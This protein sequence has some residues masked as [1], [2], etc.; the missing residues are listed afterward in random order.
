MTEKVTR[1]LFLAIKPDAVT[2]AAIH[3]LAQRLQKAARFTPADPKWVPLEN[4]HLTLQFLGEVDGPKADR[5]VESF[6]NAFTD[7]EEFRLDFRRI[8]FFPA[9]SN[10]P[11]RVIWIGVHNA[12]KALQTVRERAAAL[13]RSL[14][15]SLTEQ[16]FTPHL[17][18]ARLKSTKGLGPLRSILDP[19]R[20]W[21]CG[22]SA[23]REIHL[24]ES[25]T[26]GGVARYESLCTATLQN[27]TR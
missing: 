4:I 1:R 21:K 17:T 19:Y 13:I 16:A 25:H 7:I 27:C 9:E 20:F 10:Q 23:V 3:D 14:G 11:P 5:L 15:L 24:M 6:P 22:V 2:E 8:E 26:G 18:L 12:P